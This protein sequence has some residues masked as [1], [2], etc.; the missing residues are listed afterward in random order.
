M[1]NLLVILLLIPSLSWGLTFKNGEQ[2]D[3][4]NTSKNMDSSDVLFKPN[5]GLS[6]NDTTINIPGKT[7]LSKSKHSIY[8]ELIK[9]I[10]YSLLEVMTNDTRFGDTSLKFK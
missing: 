2:T 8:Q 9:D 6:D 7:G 5:A 4:N 10:N 1:K 3:E